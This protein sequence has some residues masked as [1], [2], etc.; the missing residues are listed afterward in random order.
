MARD[1]FLELD[2]LEQN[3]RLFPLGAFLQVLRA[4]DGC[5]VSLYLSSTTT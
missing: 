2:D 4:A 5:E 3:G 1:Y